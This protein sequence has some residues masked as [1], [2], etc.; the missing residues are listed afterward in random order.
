MIT[1]AELQEYIAN[2]EFGTVL[3]VLVEAG[4]LAG[5][6]TAGDL[7]RALATL[8][9][10]VQIQDDIQSVQL[11][12][13]FDQSFEEIAYS[14]VAAAV[15]RTQT[16]INRWN[17]EEGAG[18]KRIWKRNWRAIEDNRLAE[19]ERENLLAKERYKKARAKERREKRRSRLPS[20]KAQRLA[21]KAAI[22]ARAQQAQR[23]DAM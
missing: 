18:Y 6:W 11:P 3:E 12:N 15:D 4:L 5:Q 7:E 21:R 14:L 19:L 2:P 16:K 13:V 23:E 9:R 20:L 17:S 10:R 22:R 1:Q 8:S